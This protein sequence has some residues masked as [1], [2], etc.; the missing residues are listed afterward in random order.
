MAAAGAVAVEAV[1]AETLL[2]GWGANDPG[3][4]VEVRI[5]VRGLPR[6]VAVWGDVE[7]GRLAGASRVIDAGRGS[8]WFGDR[9][10][11]QAAL[12]EFRRLDER[13]GDHDGPT[14][15]HVTLLYLPPEEFER[16]AGRHASWRGRLRLVPYRY[17]PRAAR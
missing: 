14:E 1:G 7:E 5:A 2:T 4:P 11:R 15:G 17:A 13:P 12:G 8:V 9:E 3:V 10:A 6:G 16:L